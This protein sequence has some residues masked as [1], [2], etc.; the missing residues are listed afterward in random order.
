MDSLKEKIF[1]EYKFLYEDGFINESVEDQGYLYS[2]ITCI[3]Q[4]TGLVFNFTQERGLIT[5]DIS[6]KSLLEN[7]DLKKQPKSFDF[8]YVLKLLY[9]DKDFF[10]L[11]TFSYPSV[12]KSELNKIT[13]LFNDNN[14]LDTINKILILQKKYSKIRW[15][16]PSRFLK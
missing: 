16:N 14:V 2:S 12:I 7:Q 3:N 6:T 5:V 10:E 1:S 11:E 13:V 9:P 15:K 8:F 4:N